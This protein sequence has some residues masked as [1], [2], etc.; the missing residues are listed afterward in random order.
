MYRKEIHDIRQAVDSTESNIAGA[1]TTIPE[2][3][4]NDLQDL[5]RKIKVLRE[6]LVGA[7]NT[8]Y[9]YECQKKSCKLPCKLDLGV[10]LDDLTFCIDSLS[11][12]DADFKEMFTETVK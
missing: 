11:S 4:A 12:G 1:I 3:I 10:K 2:N 9:H 7:E 6:A 8:R 5:K